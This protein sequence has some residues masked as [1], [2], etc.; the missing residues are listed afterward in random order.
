[1]LQ[2]VRRVDFSYF[3]SADFSYYLSTR[4]VCSPPDFTEMLPLIPSNTSAAGG[5]NLA[6]YL[7]A[8]GTRW[9]ETLFFGYSSA[10]FPTTGFT[11]ELFT[12][13]LSQLSYSQQVFHL[14]YS[15]KFSTGFGCLDN[16]FSFFSG[17][18]QSLLQN[19][20]CFTTVFLDRWGLFLR[21]FN[22]QKWCPVGSA[23]HS[24]RFHFD[25]GAGV[26][27]STLSTSNKLVFLLG[28]GHGYW[29]SIIAIRRSDLSF[30]TDLKVL[31]VRL[32]DVICNDLFIY[33]SS[34]M[35]GVPDA[36]AGC[37]AA[38]AAVDVDWFNQQKLMFFVEAVT[39]LVENFPSV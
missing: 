3:K 19:L 33:P 32:N 17:A 34:F 14:C 4:P 39:P 23:E 36:F 24:L 15:S 31:Q 16:F 18:F 1:M 22:H 29:S 38:T 7:E 35:E 11:Q 12:T 10:G 37:L 9:A 8:L 21:C 6:L 5:S 27:E 20:E 26:V 25:E 13:H 2:L 28:E 30:L